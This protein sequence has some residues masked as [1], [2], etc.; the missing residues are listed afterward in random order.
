MDTVKWMFNYIWQHKVLFTLGII[1]MTI[2]GVSNIGIIAVQQYFIDNVFLGGKQEQFF[3]LFLLFVVCL[4]TFTLFYTI[5]PRPLHK[6]VAQIDNKL[7]EQFLL[8][9]YKM[10]IS[11]I[12]K[13]RTAQFSQYFSRDIPHVALLLG[14]EI[15]RFFYQ[16]IKVIVIAIIIA[17]S[18]PMLL[19]IIILS[20]LCYLVATSFF[21]E[22]GKLYSKQVNEAKS[23]LVVVLEEGVSS[24][25]EV[26]AYNR[27]NWEESK[28]KKVFSRYL[29]RVMD[30]GKL[31]NLQMFV[32]DPIRWGTVLVV[33]AYGG[34]LVI[35]NAMT[36]GAFVVVLQLTTLMMFDFQEMFNKV[37]LIYNRLANVERIR[38]VLDCP[39]PEQGVYDV[40]GPIHSLQLSQVS[41]HYEQVPEYILNQVSF[42]IPI[43]K[44]VAIV[45][46]SGSGKSTIAQLLLAFQKPNE[47]AVLVN[48]LDLSEINEKSWRNK[49]SVVF[50]EPYLFPNTLRFNLLLGNENISEE[51]MI[52]ICKKARI[53]EY[54]SSLP[55]QY[56]TVIGERGI[57]L[58]GGQRQRLAIAR[59]ILRNTEILVLDEATS[60]LDQETEFFVQQELDELRKGKTSI[61]IAHRLSTIKN[62]DEIIVLDKGKI[63]EQGTHHELLSHNHIYA[64]LIKSQERKE[65]E[66]YSVNS[67]I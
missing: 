37:M 14:E 67:A 3:P 54:I 26:I 62:A 49:I 16:A 7:S 8:Y 56:D 1:F 13:Q 12:Q 11:S 2:E 33:L 38:N 19:G 22:K 27:M 35:Q 18:S 40:E 55:D 59:A 39:L 48:D 44:K 24:T 57:T 28:F 23:D 21:K 36:P 50:Q 25:R 43:G 31:M 30:E 29:S 15:P 4:L 46:K 32:S 61:I 51:S 5:G 10:P 42:T 52:E 65:K 45:G 20:S 9:M 63:V 17:W 41:F 47:G 6:A 66:S 64:E 60:A 58:S 53:H 34:Y